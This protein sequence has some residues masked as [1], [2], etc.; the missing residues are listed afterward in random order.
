ML[1][2]FCLSGCEPDNVLPEEEVP[3]AEDIFDLDDILGDYQTYDSHYFLLITY[4]YGD[5]PYLESVDSTITVKDTIHT[6]T[7][8]GTDSFHVPYRWQMLEPYFR[9]VPGSLLYLDS[10][11]SQEKRILQFFPEQDSF[12]FEL[13]FRMSG[14]GTQSATIYHIL[15]GKKIK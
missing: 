4:S 2:T 7:A 12:Y 6:I 13:R 11:L 14:G 5:I 8:F 3:P 10:T 9:Y 15:K 1:C